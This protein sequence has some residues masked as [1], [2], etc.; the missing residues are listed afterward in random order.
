MTE[1]DDYEEFLSIF[2][3][4]GK[5]NYKWKIISNDSNFINE[6]ENKVYI[7]E[8]NENN[9]EDIIF[10]KQ[11]YIKKNNTDDKKQIY[12]EIYLNN[13]LKNYNYFLNNIEFIFSE[14]LK[15]IFLI[16]KENNTTS[17]KNIINSRIY[18]LTPDL[19][20]WIVY[21]I[22]FGLYILHSN[23]I[24]HH[25][26][27]PSNILINE[28]GS[29]SICDFGSAIFKNEK[30]YSYTLYYSSPE[31]LTNSKID[32]KYDM[33]ALGVIILE[34]FLKKNRIFEN[35][36]IKDKK[37]QLKYIL[38][39]FGIN[40]NNNKD[41]NPVLDNRYLE[42]INDE[43]AKN[44]IKNLLNFNPK[45]RL[46]AEEVLNSDYL[47]EYKGE[48]SLEINLFSNQNYYNEI[49][50]NEIKNE[51]FIKIIKNSLV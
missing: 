10:V 40:E 29:I 48:D 22:T 11:I 34:L 31:F 35:K 14:N 26:I 6:E 46:S 39:N 17:L 12:K 13:C 36:D 49:F 33:W 16:M 7:G 50:K 25:D 2:P 43:Q 28:E 27:K 32:E 37:S 42:A 51:E 4:N 30:S 38:I 44:L 24:I 20:K 23:N 9:K 3:M 18:N 15:F 47:N 1:N 41:I 19:I 45:E 8:K 5:N 21:Q